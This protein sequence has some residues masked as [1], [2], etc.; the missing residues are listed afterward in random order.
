[1]KG[2]LTVPGK[3]SLGVEVRKL[4]MGFLLTQQNLAER[5]AVPR[6]HVDSL[7]HNYPVPLDSKRRILKELWALKSKK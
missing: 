6:E 3:V 5:A 1:M 7:E 2:T 4:R